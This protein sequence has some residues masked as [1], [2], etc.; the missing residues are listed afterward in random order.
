MDSSVIITI[1]VKGGFRFVSLA[2]VQGYFA[3]DERLSLSHLQSLVICPGMSSYVLQ[4]P[5]N[6]QEQ[7][8]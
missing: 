6:R 3:S 2:S 8:H 4:I 5:V 1:S 7:Q